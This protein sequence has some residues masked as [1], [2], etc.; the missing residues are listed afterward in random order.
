M[1]PLVVIV[2]A[3]QVMPFAIIDQIAR[4]FDAGLAVCRRTD[5]ELRCSVRIHAQVVEGLSA[6][7]RG[8]SVIVL[9]HEIAGRS[10][11]LHPDL[12]RERAPGPQQ[13]AR[14]GLD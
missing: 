14:V 2:D 4:R 9:L 1:E 12:E 8:T 5:F 11:G 10:E 3:D 13:V 7:G 6:A